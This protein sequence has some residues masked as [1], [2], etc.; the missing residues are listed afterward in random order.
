MPFGMANLRPEHTGISVLLHAYKDIDYRTRHA[1]RIKAYPGKYVE[2]RTT[3]IAI[4]TR[5]GVSAEVI[6]RATIRGRALQEA[7]RFVEQNWRP[8]IMYWYNPDYGQDDLFDEL[9]A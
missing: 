1:P 4:P 5:E 8:L 9:Q 3:V 7:I 2:G 6:G